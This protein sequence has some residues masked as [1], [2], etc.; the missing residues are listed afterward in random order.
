MIINGSQPALRKQNGG[1]R[2]YKCVFFDL[3]HTLWDY[4]CNAREM[5]LELHASHDLSEKGISFEDF[6]RLFRSVNL[7]LW[8]LYDRGLIDNEVI[9]TQR[10]TKVLAG[11]GLVDNKLSATLSYEYLYGCPKKRNLVPHAIPVLDYLSKI[12]RL[13]V[14]T[15]GF[16]EIQ[17]VKLSS[18][19]IT[20]YFDHVITSQKAG[21][22]KPAREIFDY[23]LSVNNLA[24]HDVI[25]IGDNLVTDIG[26]ARNAC[27][28]TVFYNPGALEHTAE[29]SH[30]IRCLSELQTIL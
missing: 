4:E 20:H 28:D 12:Y 5:L 22:K 10:F 14:V 26:G 25:M 23:A 17:N 13:T 27:I 9:R 29:V 21:H 15:N 2:D 8:D 6:H 1:A 7:E 30:E 11:F 19:N 18:G 16:E 3:D 24:C